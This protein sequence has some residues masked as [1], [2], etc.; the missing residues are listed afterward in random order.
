MDGRSRPIP[1]GD[2]T[3][4]RG[5][6]WRKLRWSNLSL[7][8]KG[9]V[10]VAIPV[11]G[12]L[13][14]QTG[15]LVAQGGQT[16]AAEAA[17]HAEE[18]RTSLRSILITALD[19]ETSVRGYLLTQDRAHLYAFRQSVISMPQHLSRLRALAT[20]GAEEAAVGRIERFAVERLE[21][22]DRLRN[23]PPGPDRQAILRTG[24][25]IMGFLRS[26]VLTFQEREASS[27][28]EQ[29]D[30]ADRYRTIATAVAGGGVVLGL[31]GGLAAAAAFTSGV[32]R[33]IRRLE[34]NAERL[35]RGEPLEALPPGEDEIGH[36]GRAMAETAARLGE[37][38]RA[39]SEMNQKLRQQ[40]IIDDLTEL[41]N[42]RA[43]MAI[44]EHEVRSAARTGQ[45]LAVLFADLDRMKDINDTFG[46][47]EGDCALRDVA[48]IL[49]TCLRSSDVVARLGGD[50]FS[51]LL[52]DCAPDQA[53]AIL[54]RIDEA[55]QRHRG[56]RPFELS[57]SLGV[58]THQP[59]AE[60][61]F[62][63]LI[64]RADAAMYDQKAA[65]AGR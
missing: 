65:R 12:L 1:L 38:E 33:R 4:P 62:E 42:R 45:P 17:R 35:A 18:T 2:M 22:A 7:R 55:V 59:G 29:T 9:Y 51:A 31:L 27:F 50:E 32:T 19:A 3:G 39:I 57:L 11:A 10:V 8:A 6:R 20:G 48:A 21:V 58:A 53:A 25:T 16:R 15:F 54:D 41:H 37:A 34:G 30:R 47:A 63:D 43:F 36:L 52:P 28:T 13:A 26:E 14:A 46:H 56:T 64:R 40:A 44:G 24:K 23:E 49:R 5:S 60:E 61:E